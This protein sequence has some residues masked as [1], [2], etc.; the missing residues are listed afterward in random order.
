MSLYIENSSDS[1]ISGEYK[2]TK[3]E[4]SEKPEVA[5]RHVHVRSK[6]VWNEKTFFFMVASLSGKKVKQRGQH[7]YLED[8]S[9]TFTFNY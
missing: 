6:K 8:A 5:Y 9:K 4:Q 2:L 7:Y 3:L 1:S